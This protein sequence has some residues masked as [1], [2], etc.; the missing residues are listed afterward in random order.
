MKDVR[1]I[2]KY[3]ENK[4]YELLNYFSIKKETTGDI[5]IAFNQ[6]KIK[7]LYIKMCGMQLK[8]SVEKNLW[9]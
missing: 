6:M 5:R 3:L 9:Y 1:E 2:S 7:I 4:W 8:Q